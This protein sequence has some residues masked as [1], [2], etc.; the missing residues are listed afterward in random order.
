MHRPSKLISLTVIWVFL[1]YAVKGLAYLIFTTAL[2]ARNSYKS[3]TGEVQ[4]GDMVCPESIAL[5][6]K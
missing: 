6:I 1:H 2:K 3:F 4:R 5:L